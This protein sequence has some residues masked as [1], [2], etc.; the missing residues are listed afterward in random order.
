MKVL[1]TGASGFVGSHIL[2][3]LVAQELPTVLL[4]RGT[5]HHRFIAHHLAHV[6]VAMGAITDVSTLGLALAGV[7]HVIHCAGA[8]KAVRAA[9]LDAVNG[10][11]TRNVVDAVNALGGQVQRF[12][13]VSSL[14]VSGP[15][16]AAAPARE[17]SPPNPVSAYGRSKLAGEQAVTE[18]CRR[19]FVIL[20]PGG[21]YGPR[22]TEFLKLFKTARARVTPVFNGG[23][24][25]LSLV[26][27]PDLARVAVACLTAPGIESEHFRRCPVLQVASP[28]V[29]TA[30]RLTNAIAACLGVRTWRLP[31]SNAVLRPVCALAGA[32][33]RLTGQASILA[34]DKYHELTAPGWVADVS[35]LQATLG[36]DCPTSLS[37]GLQSTRDAYRQAGWL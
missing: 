12:I 14:A 36:I 9:E 19:P 23:R 35:R 29:V 37:D 5:S 16:T 11:G 30:A 17:T 18:R 26:F 27:A 21:V 4:L 31:L 13:H 15:G 24:Q 6:T 33:A 28:E 22:D 3:V 25:E 7:T 1:L 32:W 2:D 34:H 20:R 10:G 8:T